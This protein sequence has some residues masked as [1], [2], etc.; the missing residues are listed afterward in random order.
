MKFKDCVCHCSAGKKYVDRTFSPHL[1]RKILLLVLL[2]FMVSCQKSVNEE[3]TGATGSPDYFPPVGS[4]TWDIVTPE[5]LGWNTS[6]IPALNKLLSDNGTRAFLVLKDGRI[7]LEEYFGKNLA[8][9][10]SFSQS[11]N[12]YWAS[13]GKTLTAFIVGKAL[14][15]GYLRLKDP[16]SV[17]LGTGWTSLSPLQESQITVW[18]QLTMTSGLDDGVPDSHSTKPE[19]LRY[20]AA[21]GSRWAYHNGPYTLLENVVARAS[22]QDF[23]AYFKARLANKIG[24]DGFWQW[25]DNDHVFF[26]TARSMARFGLLILNKGIWKNDKILANSDFYTEMV[27]TSQVL[28]KSYGYLWWLNGKE[29]F[30]LPESQLLFPGSITPS[31]PSD[32]IAGMGKNGQY[33][34]VVPSQNLVVVRLGES[35][36][37]VPVPFLFLNDIWG[38]LN[39]VIK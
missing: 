26:S 36:E 27:N 38:K 10:S 7:V 8:G 14:E 22:A 35:P 1:I 5:S 4:G 11:S 21:P 15:E 37:S 33:V 13:A 12:W 29:S 31:A 6:A 23:D 19:E 34:C 30:R 25:V 9:I 28:N 2:P 18:H 32:M 39:Q 24:M 17:Y 16:T 3:G 20:K